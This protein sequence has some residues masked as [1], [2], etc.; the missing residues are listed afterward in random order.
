MIWNM[1]KLGDET[2]RLL[3]REHERWLNRAIKA[4]GHYPTIPTRR[5]DDGG[6]S[7]LL[8]RPGGARLA[9]LW[10]R[11]ALDRVDLDA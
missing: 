2:A 3:R 10:W 1:T 11:R 5:A 6:F 4:P 7:G 9:E 8:A